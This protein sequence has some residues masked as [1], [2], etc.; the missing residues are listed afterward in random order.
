MPK[1]A[2]KLNERQREYLERELQRTLEAEL[3]LLKKEKEFDSFYSAQQI[4][5][6]LIKTVEG[7]I[8]TQ[9]TEAESN[10]QDC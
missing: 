3:E 4:A 6:R 10:Q 5:S 1:Q 2:V 8:M 7:A 9:L